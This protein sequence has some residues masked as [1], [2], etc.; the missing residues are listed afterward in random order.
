LYEV[1]GRWKHHTHVI[2][3]L[4][5]DGEW[6]DAADLLPGDLIRTLDGDY[7]EVASM[8]IVEREQQMF[9]LTVDEAR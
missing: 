3:L 1:T 6:V 7:G 4:S 2:V 9:N 8:R 5:I